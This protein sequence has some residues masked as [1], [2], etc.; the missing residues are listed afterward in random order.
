MRGVVGVVVIGP[1]SFVTDLLRGGRQIGLECL[2]EATDA[3]AAC[4]PATR[5][6]KKL[7]KQLPIAEKLNEFSQQEQSGGVSWRN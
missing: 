1:A 2:P 3:A 6:L 4:E 5:R 7:K